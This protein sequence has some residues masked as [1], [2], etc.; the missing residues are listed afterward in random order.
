MRIKFAEDP[1]REDSPIRC[2]VAILSICIE[3]RCPCLSIQFECFPMLNNAVAAP[4][5]T[6]RAF[7]LGLRDR[8]IDIHPEFEKDP[9]VH[10]LAEIVR[11][12]LTEEDKRR[13]TVWFLTK[14][15]AIIEST[16]SSQFD[17]TDLPNA[18]EGGMIG[19]PKVFPH[20]LFLNFTLNNEIWAVN[21]QYCVQPGCDCVVTDLSFHEVM[22]AIGNKDKPIQDIP[23]LRYNYRY[24]TFE[25]V[26]SGAAGSPPLDELLAAL[27]RKLPSLNSQLERHHRILQSIYARHYSEQ[28]RSQWQSLFTNQA[29]VVSHKIGRNEPCPCGSGRK[30]KQCCLNKAK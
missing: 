16:P 10:R 11:A 8:S 21:D 3:A 29:P 6:M 20:S 13:L 2:H 1:Q 5:K 4:P 26:E 7:W 9:V 25:P 30:Y 18:D 14:K 24:E 15:H 17:I 27:K 19:F 22:G 28:A 12:E 23:C